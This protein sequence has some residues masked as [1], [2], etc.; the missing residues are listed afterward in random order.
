MAGTVRRCLVDVGD[1]G[2]A[3]EADSYEL[4]VVELSD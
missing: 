4:N 1:V 3:S 2:D